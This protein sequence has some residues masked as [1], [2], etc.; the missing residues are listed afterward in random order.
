[1]W[2]RMWWRAF[3]RPTVKRSCWVGFV[4]THDSTLRSVPSCPIKHFCRMSCFLNIVWPSVVSR[5]DLWGMRWWQ[6]DFV[7]RINIRILTWGNCK[8]F[9][10]CLKFQIEMQSLHSAVKMSP[11]DKVE[12]FLLVASVSMLILQ[13]L[14]I[15]LTLLSYK[16]KVL[17]C[18][19][20]KIGSYSYSVT[21]KL[22]S[23]QLSYTAVC[24]GNP[25]LGFT[26]KLR[27]GQK[28]INLIQH[29]AV[30]M[31]NNAV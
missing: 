24:S 22:H 26:W 12:S 25:F 15:D 23:F 5:T 7:S 8:I 9:I 28:K 31:E 18:W 30:R 17:S 1:M 4:R 3:S 20:Q 2:W 27:L 13:I 14:M 16:L 21:R 11:A 19:N 6:I 29:V 10:Y